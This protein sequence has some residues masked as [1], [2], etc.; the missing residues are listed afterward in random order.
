MG[1]YYLNSNDERTWGDYYLNN[2]DERT[3]GDC[4][5]NSNDERTLGDYYLNE[6]MREPWVISTSTVIIERNLDDF[7]FNSNAERIWG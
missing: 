7:N 4:Y 3:L 6:T 5:L 1:D 2:N